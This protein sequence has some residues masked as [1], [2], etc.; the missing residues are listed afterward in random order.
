MLNTKE[1]EIHMKRKAF[2]IFSKLIVM[3]IVII[4]MMICY[5]ATLGF[6]FCVTIQNEKIEVSTR[7]T[8]SNKKTP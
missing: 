1:G 8:N 7:N 5:L 2:L 4:S 6:D 3:I